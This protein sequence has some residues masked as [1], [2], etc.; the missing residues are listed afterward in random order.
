MIL[1]LIAMFI[2]AAMI[3]TL[4][5]LNFELYLEFGRTDKMSINTSIQAIIAKLIIGNGFLNRKND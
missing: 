3:L 5:Y 2:N 1:G 4:G